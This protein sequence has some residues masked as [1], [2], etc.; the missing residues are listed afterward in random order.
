MMCP[1]TELLLHDFQR[2][3]IWA[4]ENERAE[5]QT[6]LDRIEAALKEGR[7]FQQMADDLTPIQSFSLERE[8]SQQ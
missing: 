7:T 8:R 2:W 6:Q 3:T 4:I 1:A 5:R